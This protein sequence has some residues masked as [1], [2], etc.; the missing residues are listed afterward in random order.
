MD[1]CV[2]GSVLGAHCRA[3]INDPN[4][5]ML[6][7]NNG[8]EYLDISYACELRR[9]YHTMAIQGL[10][11]LYIRPPTHESFQSRINDSRNFG[12]A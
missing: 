2:H 11:I 1:G 10:I 6:G 3:Y 5:Q 7:V 12:S 4:N 8:F 9:L